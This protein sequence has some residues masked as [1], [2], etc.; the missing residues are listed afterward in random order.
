MPGRPR[1]HVLEEESC[2]ALRALLPA[3]W[4]VEPVR[5]DY[6]LDARVE[7][8]RDGRAT[9]RAFW[10]QLKGTD[11]PDLR[12]ALGV[13]FATTTLNYLSVQADPVLL[14]RFHAPSGRSFGSWL[15]RQ[16]IQLKRAG[17]KSATVRWRLPEELLASSP[18]ELD[19][20][21]TRFRRIG[22]P[23]CL[24]LN[25]SFAAVGSAAP[26]AGRVVPLLKSTITAAGVPLRLVDGDAGDI[27]LLIGPKKVEVDTPLAALRAEREQTDDP[28]A[29]ADDAAAALAVS[30]GS[31]GLP[32]AAVDLVLRCSGAQLLQ[33]EDT[34]GRLAQAFAASGRW[35]DASNLALDCLSGPS[36][37]EL[38]GRLL[39]VEVLMSARD[40]SEADARHVAANL[41][42]L[43]RRQH[44]RGDN[45]GAAWYSAGNWLFH[46]VRDYPAALRAYEA[47]ADA[48]PDYR[49]Q[50][51]WLQETAASLFET[52][53][54]TA[55]AER[56][57]E[58]RAVMASPALG[59]LP[60]IADCMAHAG[61][62]RGAIDLLGRY[63]RAEP[64]PEPAWVLK[65]LALQQL[66]IGEGRG[67]QG[68]AADE[69]DGDR[70]DGGGDEWPD[71][72]V[73][74]HTGLAAADVLQQLNEAASAGDP[75]AFLAVLSAACAFPA[76]GCDEFWSAL[77]LLAWALH[78]DHGAGWSLPKEVFHAAVDTAVY[79]RGDN[80]LRDL[81]G[82]GA[83][84][85][86]GLVDEVER[87]VAEASTAEG[88]VLVRFINDDGNRDVLE[89]GFA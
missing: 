26:L 71:W 13:S 18:E 43:A 72:P 63:R 22:S 83:A 52:G 34:A 66:D 82:G 62:R 53:E 88:R 10:A 15:H 59:L 55:A 68:D 11:E 12:R 7:V 8:F 74:V 69:Q 33:G 67:R 48:R 6:G 73:L 41:L 65:L 85:P 25:V 57:K 23:A 5:R 51:Y 21:V 89:I 78:E 75:A 77:L 40:P 61:D 9:G 56:Y 39:D 2:I 58:A 3:D 81:L 42:E 37:R 1:E 64:E 79:R 38:L 86:D 17:Q 50:D 47:A 20:E 54:Y 76:A 30:L 31:I 80:F 49:K 45:A 14:V 16:D 28:M 44:A 29:V 60:R 4:T 36:G 87:R 19:E 27:R 46:T 24:P 84:L 70:V 32:S 35:R